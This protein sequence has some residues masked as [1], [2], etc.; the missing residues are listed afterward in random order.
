MAN[1]ANAIEF[2]EKVLDSELPVLV[3]FSAT[4]CGPCHMLGPVI[5]ELEAEFTG[6]AGVAKVDIDQCRNLAQHYN[7][8]AVPT[9]MVFNGGRP[10]VKVVGAA[11]KERIAEMVNGVISGEITPLD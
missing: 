10:G 2:K 3:D 6:K 1:I 5:D 4:W 7:I 9:L 11:P 8:G